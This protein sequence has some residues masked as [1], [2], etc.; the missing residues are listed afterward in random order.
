MKKSKTNTSTAGS[1]KIFSVKYKL[2]IIFGILAAISISALSFVA[3]RTARHVV[4]E[5]KECEK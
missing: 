1:R 3:V 2:M 5:K 4:M